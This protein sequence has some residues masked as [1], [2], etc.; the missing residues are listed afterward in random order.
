[1]V[2]FGDFFGV[3]ACV[4]HCRAMNGWQKPTMASWQHPTGVTVE[5]LGTEE[6]SNGRSCEEH[7]VCGAVVDV[8]MV[9][10]LRRVQI[11]DPDGD[12]EETAIAAYWVTDGVDRCR[13]GFLGRHTIKHWKQFDGKL[14]QIVDIYSKESDS[15]T[16]RKKFHRNRGCC[17][18]IIIDSIKQEDNSSESPLRKKQCKG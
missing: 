10:R 18:A 1:M 16:K 12:N 7:D 13:V 2:E 9:V 17:R 8:D 11:A 14:A 4:A 5:V 6:S 3:C 15:P